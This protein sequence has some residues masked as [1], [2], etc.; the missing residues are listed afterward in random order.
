ML[1]RLGYA[2]VKLLKSCFKTKVEKSRFRWC[3]VQYHFVNCTVI[4]YVRTPCSILENLVVLKLNQLEVTIL[5]IYKF[6][7]RF[8]KIL[9]SRN[10][11]WDQELWRPLINSPCYCCLMNMTTTIVSKG[12]LSNCTF[13]RYFISR[14]LL[15]TLR[16]VCYVNVVGRM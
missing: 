8:C 14:T 9:F 4:W 3:P 15:V 5:P 1:I 10:F 2:N 11:F 6:I 13:N 12:L 7:K 16:F